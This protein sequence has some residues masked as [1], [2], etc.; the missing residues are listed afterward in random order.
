MFRV[1]IT[2]ISSKKIER[3]RYNIQSTE[4]F[5]GGIKRY[6]AVKNLANLSKEPE[7]IPLLVLASQSSDHK[8][9]HEATKA[10]WHLNTSAAVDALCMEAISEPSHGTAE[11]K[12]Q[13][14]DERH[15][16]PNHRRRRPDMCDRW[17]DAVRGHLSNLCVLGRF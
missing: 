12:E 6:T 3:L 10:L 14:S 7:A 9:A 4:K 15:C 1:V 17:L 13:T 2:M 5:F 8:I 11:Y 16:D